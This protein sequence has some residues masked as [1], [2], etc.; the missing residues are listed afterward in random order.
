MVAKVNSMKDALEE[1]AAVAARATLLDAANKE[2]AAAA[3]AEAARRERAEATL[4]DVEARNDELE[5][6]IAD[7]ST[8]LSWFVQE[9]PLN[10]SRAS[11]RSRSC[12][13]SSSGSAFLSGV[14]AG[15][16]TPMNGMG[17][18]TVGGDEADASEPSPLPGPGPEP[19]TPH[20]DEALLETLRSQLA[21]TAEKA[22]RAE[23]DSAGDRERLH[24]ALRQVHH[25]TRLEGRPANAPT[26]PR[27]PPG[28]L[29]HPPTH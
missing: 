27:A 18:W 23:Q 12:S 29:T 5:R 19:R 4:G 15:G 22:R 17:A 16:L 10:R 2:L 26:H 25:P 28:P 14:G 21:A 20:P 8:E 13:R 1:Q 6:Q 3:R 11:S 9:S 24:A 7:L